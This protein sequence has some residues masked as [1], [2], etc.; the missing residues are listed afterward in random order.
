[1]VA[2][3]GRAGR[4]AAAYVADGGKHGFAFCFCREDRARTM[5]VTDIVRDFL[6]ALAIIAVLAFCLHY[7]FKDC[8]LLSVIVYLFLTSESFSLFFRFTLGR[9]NTMIFN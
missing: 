4:E 2:E 5:P 8:N 9:F 6:A 3:R 1:M 7:C